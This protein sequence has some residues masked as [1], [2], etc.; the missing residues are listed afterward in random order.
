MRMRVGWVVLLQAGSRAGSAGIFSQWT[1]QTQ[2]RRVCSHDG[3]IKRGMYPERVCGHAHA[4]EVSRALAS[5]VDGCAA[6]HA[7][8]GGGVDGVR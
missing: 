2:E 6:A 1:N 5:G 3:P 7:A 4:G 8:V